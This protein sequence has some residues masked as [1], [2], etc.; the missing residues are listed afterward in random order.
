MPLPA[1]SIGN[2]VVSV[3][4][5]LILPRLEHINWAAYTSVMLCARILS[6][7]GSGMMALTGIVFAIAFVMIQSGPLAYSSRLVVVFASNLVL[8]QTLGIFFA[9][10]LAALNW[11]DRGGSG[12]APLFSNCWSAFCPSSACWHS[13]GWCRVSAICNPQRYCEPLEREG[14]P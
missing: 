1:D 8:F 9:T 14:G 13:P 7:V 11:T 2:T 6:A 5:R 3:T 12:G 4:A 10:F